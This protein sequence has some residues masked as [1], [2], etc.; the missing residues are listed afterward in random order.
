MIDIAR[1]KQDIKFEADLFGVNLKFVS[2]WG[3]FSP[4]EI[5]QGTKLL[6]KY[7]KI[8]QSDNCLD[9]G[10]GYGVI[11]LWLAKLANQG[12]IHMVDK[13]YIAVEYSKTNA[14][15]NN[16]DNVRIYLSNGFSEVPDIKFDKIISNVPAKIGKEL[17]TIML[18][19]AKLHLSPQGEIFLVV[20]NGLRDYMK[21]NLKEIFGNFKKIKQ[22]AKYTVL[23][24]KLI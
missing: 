8:N 10:C 3:I 15:I 21:K 12:Q 7:I 22:G 20:I 18:V 4:R 2:T 1:L 5:D 13:D 16:I 14:Q 23:M 19:E 9:L 24:A 6:L 11:G 17:T